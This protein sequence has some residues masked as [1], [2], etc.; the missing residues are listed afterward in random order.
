MTRLNP[1]LG[2]LLRM[3]LIGGGG[4]AFIGKVHA[5]AAKLDH[6]AEIVAAALSRDLQTSQSSAAAF[7]LTPDQA[8]G[9]RSR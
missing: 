7:G 2:R 8:Y 5:V 6:R 9:V 3:G 4:A 1:P